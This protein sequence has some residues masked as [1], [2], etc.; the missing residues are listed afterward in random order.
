MIQVR[1]DNALQRW[2]DL[3]QQAANAIAGLSD[4]PRQSQEKVQFVFE[5]AMSGMESMRK[6]GV[7]VGIGTDLLG[8]TYVQQCRTCLNFCVSR[9]IMTERSRYAEKE[10]VR[11]LA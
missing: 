9:H 8:K 3:G 10:E 5:K 2:M 6:A 1:P 11:C 4:F 7:Q